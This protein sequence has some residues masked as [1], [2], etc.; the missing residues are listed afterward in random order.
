MFIK[1]QEYIKCKSYLSTNHEF[2][3]IQV[4]FTNELVN[5]EK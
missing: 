4:Y 5:L 3:I 2:S 1:I